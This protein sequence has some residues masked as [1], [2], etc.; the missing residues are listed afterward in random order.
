M[1]FRKPKKKDIDELIKLSKLFKK[2][3]DWTDIV[4]IANIDTK[5]KAE[6]RL[7]GDNIK[8]IL[9]AEE[10][11][12]MIG[13]LAVKKYEFEEDA[14][15]EAS[16]LINKD[17]REKGLA[18]KMVNKLFQEIPKNIAVEA[19]VL[20]DNI[21]SIKTVRSLGFK[22]DRIFAEDERVKIYTKRGLK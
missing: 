3:Y 9:I 6:D 7:F 22:F 21:P 20:K 17:Y 8:Y 5:D 13:Y 1:I 15:H 14:G 19:W 4:P 10:E 16:I 18:K 12:N 2:E 11:E